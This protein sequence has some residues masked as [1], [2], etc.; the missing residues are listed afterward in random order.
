MGADLILM[1]W[2][3]DTSINPDRKAL[4]QALAAIPDMKLLEDW[5]A[6]GAELDAIDEALESTGTLAPEDHV[7]TKQRTAHLRLML[8][9]AL[10][11]L[12]DSWRDAEYI[13]IPPA[14]YTWHLVLRGGLSYGDY[15]IDRWY[16]TSLLID[17]AK[18]YPAVRAATGVIGPNI[19]LP[20][21]VDQ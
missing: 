9:D 7:S 2:T 1:A 6:L 19:Q 3:C 18:E 14:P 15:P 16:E 10:E 11:E 4:E 21:E 8:V 12:D 20:S 5:E 17:Y 13:G